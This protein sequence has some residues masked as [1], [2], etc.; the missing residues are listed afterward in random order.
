MNV[1][2][3]CSMN[4][5]RSPT[6]EKIYADKP[7]VAARSRG[8]SSN[9]RRTVSADDLRWADVIIVMEEK[10]KRRLLSDYPGEMRFQELHVLDIPDDY[11]YMDPELI[12]EITP[13][14]EPILDRS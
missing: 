8:I 10:H 7:L 3:I 2:F 11:K 13:A 4:Q 5:W 12:D 1:L 9:A 14:V 6:A